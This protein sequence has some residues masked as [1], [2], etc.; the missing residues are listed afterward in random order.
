MTTPVE[1]FF[2][3][4]ELDRIA[5]QLEADREIDS[6]YSYMGDGAVHWTRFVTWQQ[7]DTAPNVLRGA[8]ALLRD[9]HPDLLELLPGPV[10]VL[11]LGPGNAV[12]VRAVLDRLHAAGRLERYVA[13]DTSAEML[14][15]A[16][17][18]LRGW[19]GPTV[20]LDGYLRDF[21]A[22]PLEDLKGP[23]ATFAVLLGGT[24][25]NFVDPVAVLRHLRGTADVLACT[26]KVDLPGTSTAAANE[27]R[28][29][30]PLRFRTL[31]ELLGIDRASYEPEVGFDDTT[32]ERFL[33]IRTTRP[34]TVAERVR[35]AAGE[36]VLLW[37]YRHHSATDLDAMF[38]RAGFRVAVERHT[39]DG[40]FAL[41]AGVPTE[42]AGVPTEVA[43]IPA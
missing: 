24:L 32:R 29:E 19:L 30:M 41:V 4:H 8:R 18:N 6:R 35:L 26:V 43:G 40:Q 3:A 34:V 14:A 2:A 28:G 7:K 10:R 23:G 42:V 12:P 38:A 9:A 25:F 15:I 1:G 16:E 27:V 37:R 33:R 31:L 36:S 20:T 21:T 22:D 39:R 5:A 13:V 11:D 17:R